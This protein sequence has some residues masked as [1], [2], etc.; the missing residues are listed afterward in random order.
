MEEIKRIKTGIDNLDNE[1]LDGGIPAYSVNI[2]GGTPGSGKTIFSQQILFYNASPKRR[3]IYFTTISEPTAKLIHYQRSFSYFDEQK[4]RDGLIS[5]VD[6]GHVI[7]RDGLKAGIDAI[8]SAID[9]YS[10]SIV[11]IDSFKAINELAESVAEFRQFAYMLCVEL[12]AWRCTSFLVGEYTQ[13]ALDKEPIF[14]I[15]DSIIFLDNKIEGLLSKRTLHIAKMRGVNYFQGVHSIKI[16]KN[17]IDVFPR[18]KSSPQIPLEELGKERVSTGIVGL[19]EMTLGGLPKGSSTLVAGGAGT[20]KTTLALHFLVEGAK[21]K[22]PGVMVTFQENESQ[23]ENIGKGFGWDLRKYKDKSLLKIIHTPPIELNIDEHILLLKKNLKGIKRVVVDNL[24]DIEILIN[25]HV[26]Y[27]DY[28][29]SLVNLFKING[30]TSILTTETEEI[31]GSPKLSSG[32]SFIADNVF[33]LNYTN[34]NKSIKRVLTILKLR[35]SD[36][37]KMVREFKITS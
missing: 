21:N 1:I 28:V 31:F 13:Q 9:K 18:S 23:L 5:Y 2:I 27:H 14:A 25:D 15:A 22:E 10:A 26:R 12:T 29:Y 6:I 3:A 32:I 37:C 36:H 4:I 33:L 20:G 7:H 24:R 34:E 19:D 17:G 16:T 35:G 30:V 11:A 8:T